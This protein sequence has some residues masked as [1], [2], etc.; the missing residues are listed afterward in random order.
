MS[1]RQHRRCVALVL[2]VLVSLVSLEEPVSA[3]PSFVAF[4]KVPLAQLQG[5][6]PETTH[7]KQYYG[8]HFPPRLG[9]PSPYIVIVPG[10]HGLVSQSKDTLFAYAERLVREGYGAVVIDIFRGTE[11]THTCDREGGPSRAGAALSAVQFARKTGYASGRF[12]IVGQGQGGTAAKLLSGFAGAREDGVD[13]F[14]AAVALFPECEVS[15]LAIPFLILTG[16]RDNTEPASR[17]LRWFRSG[18]AA[19]LD[20]KFYPSVAQGADLFDLHPRR[21]F[22]FHV[23][24]NESASRDAVRRIIDFF[25][26]HL[27]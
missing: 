16:G 21:E 25:D 27:W 18:T 11:F 15:R 6:P 19:L 14:H 7:T 1:A 23:V 22:D 3:S 24:N 13:G 9:R 20:M 4:E 12:G 10:C 17:C 8:F 5:V 26:K 2:A